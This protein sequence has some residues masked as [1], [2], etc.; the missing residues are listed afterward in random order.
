MVTYSEQR[1]NDVLDFCE[2]LVVEIE[3]LRRGTSILE[4]R[5]RRIVRGQCTA[6][7]LRNLIQ[8]CH[9][10]RRPERQQLATEMT[11]QLNRLVDHTR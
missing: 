10:D 2:G 5:T 8:L 6:G 11:A 4:Q 1:Y 9:P 7:G 3:G